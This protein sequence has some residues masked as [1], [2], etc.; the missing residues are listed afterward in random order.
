[1]SVKMTILISK[2]DFH[3]ID[4]IFK[5]DVL[6]ALIDVLTIQYKLLTKAKQL[7]GMFLWNLLFNGSHR[8]SVR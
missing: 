8:D 4:L 7:L 1:M 3:K 6:A 5:C 2:I